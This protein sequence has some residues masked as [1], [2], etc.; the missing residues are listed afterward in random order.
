MKRVIRKLKK[1]WYTYTG[2]DEAFLE[3][4]IQQFREAAVCAVKTSNSIAICP[5]NPFW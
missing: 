1:L 4:K 2:N 5:V 3:L